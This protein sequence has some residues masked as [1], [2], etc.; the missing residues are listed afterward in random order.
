MYKAKA[1]VWGWVKGVRSRLTRLKCWL[2]VQASIPDM[3]STT[4]LYLEISRL[5]KAKADA[6]A[7]AVQQHVATRLQ[8]LGRR[9][10]AIPADTV[11]FFVRQAASL[12]YARTCSLSG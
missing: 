8:Q 12:R 1:A 7:A 10:D 4:A 6:D 5:Y 9:P 2:V 11:R 3:W